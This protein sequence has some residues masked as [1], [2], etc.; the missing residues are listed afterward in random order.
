MEV[1]GLLLDPASETPVLL[2]QAVGGTLVLPI[3]IDIM[4]PWVARRRAQLPA[5]P[6]F[7][8]PSNVIM[9][10]TSKGLEAFIAGT[11]PGIR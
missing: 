11:E 5:P 4:K 6:S 2:L 10:M 9:V 3:W 7:E 8:R 1:K